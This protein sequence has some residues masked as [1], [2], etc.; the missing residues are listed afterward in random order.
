MANRG[1]VIVF[2][3]ALGLYTGALSTVVAE[4]LQWKRA[5]FSDFIRQLASSRGKNPDDRGVLQHLGQE[6]VQKGPEDFVRSVLGMA[7]WSPGENLVLDGL[8]HAEVF[9]ELRSQVGPS[10]DLR[11]VHVTIADRARRADRAKRAEGFTDDQFG[12]YETDVTEAQVEE[13]P[14]YANLSLDGAEPR[15]ELAKTIIRR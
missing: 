5:R 14:A 15:G 9:R 7:K 6:I 8:R 3:G 4:T 2:S 13:T 10:A 11:V 12:Q 1:T